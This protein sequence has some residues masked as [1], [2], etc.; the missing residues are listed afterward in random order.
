MTRVRTLAIALMA[1]FALCAVS[2]AAASAALP[3]LVNAKGEALVKKKFTD[4]SEGETKLESKSGLTVTCKAAKS[5]GESTGTKTSAHNIVTFTGC[6]SSF[7]GSC[8]TKGKAA[9]EIVTN[10]LSGE[11]G[12]VNKANKEVGLELHPTS[13]TVFATFECG[14]FLKNEVRGSIIGALTPINKK[15]KTTEHFTV[16]YEK[17]AEKGTQKITK[18]EGGSEDVLESSLDGG[19]FEKANEQATGTIKFEEEAELKA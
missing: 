16:K 4:A 8:N 6:T 19:S 12:Y 1:V 15:V 11:I 5:T 17:G 9:G 14:A 18:F 13:G 3:E 7:G 10:E 2:A